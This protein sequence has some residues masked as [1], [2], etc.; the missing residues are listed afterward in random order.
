MQNFRRLGPVVAE[1]WCTEDTEESVGRKS[2]GR[3]SVGRKK[4]RE[5]PILDIKMAI[6]KQLQKSNQLNFG[7][8]LLSDQLVWMVP[9]SGSLDYGKD[10]IWGRENGQF[11]VSMYSTL[12]TRCLFFGEGRHPLSRVLDCNIVSYLFGQYFHPSFFFIKYNFNCVWS[13]WNV[14]VYF[15]CNYTRPEHHFI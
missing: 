5:I 3:K 9:Y 14:N 15:G 10:H 11:S 4:R 6:F 7:W 8:S 12:A 2:V 13:I 1:I